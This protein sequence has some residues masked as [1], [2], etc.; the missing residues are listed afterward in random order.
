MGQTPLTVSR[1]ELLR[2]GCDRAFR[3][4]LHHLLAF[5]GRLDKLR[6]GFA[7][8][9][10]LSGVQYS[11]LMTVARLNEIVGPND[12]VGIAAVAERLHLSGAF[13]TTAVNGLLAEG[14]VNKEPDHNDRRRVNL[15]LTEAGCAL[16]D[17][18]AAVQ[19]PVNDAL[20]EALSATDFDTLS[21]IAAGLVEGAERAQALQDFLRHRHPQPGKGVRASFPPPSTSSILERGEPDA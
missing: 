13:V 11:I 10:G 2:D 16:L 3:D 8:M 19:K 4:M 9:V 15:T 6:D 17:G 14:L 1:P 5:A 12:G 20:F 7:D 18:L 21:R